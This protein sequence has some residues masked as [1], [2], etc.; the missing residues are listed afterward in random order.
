MPLVNSSGQGPSRDEHA[1]QRRARQ[2]VVQLVR[3][4]ISSIVANWLEAV[5]REP[6]IRPISISDSERS[7]KLPELLWIATNIAEG[8]QFSIEDRNNF[9]EH[10]ALRYKQNYTAKLL[11]REVRVLQAAVAECIQR[12]LA[13]IEMLH[14]VPDTIR[15]MGTLDSLWEVAV[16]AL[17]R[18]AYAETPANKLSTS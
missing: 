6:E 12:N 8:R 18:Q 1:E 4:N 10:G 9:L 3:A 14:L 16:R 17:I 2:H 7:Q 13:A 11:G 15:F 5:K